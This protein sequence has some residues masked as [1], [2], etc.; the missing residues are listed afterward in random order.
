MIRIWIFLPLHRDVVKC[1]GVVRRRRQHLMPLGYIHISRGVKGIMR[2]NIKACR[3]NCAVLQLDFP[4]SNLR[5]FLLANVESVCTHDI[6]GGEF[7]LRCLD[8]RI[9]PIIGCKLRPCGNRN[10][11]A[12]SVDVRT[13][14][15]D[16]IADDVDLCIMRAACI[17]RSVEINRIVALHRPL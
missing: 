11:C 13:V 5:T 3:V 16:R 12:V 9:I 7:Y 15:I 10:C 1:N 4:A 6:L 14:C 2:C 17:H 8:R